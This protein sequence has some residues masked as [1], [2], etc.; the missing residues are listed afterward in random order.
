MNDVIN[1]KSQG[2]GFCR[3]TV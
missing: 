2:S 1:C 3:Y